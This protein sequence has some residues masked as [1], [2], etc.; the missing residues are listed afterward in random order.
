ML[1]KSSIMMLCFDTN[2]LHYLGSSSFQHIEGKSPS[3][4]H[5]SQPGRI[6]G[7]K[8]IESFDASQAPS[9]D[10]GPLV[11]KRCVLVKDWGKNQWRGTIVIVYFMICYTSYWWVFV[12]LKVALVT[13]CF[14]LCCKCFAAHIWFYVYTGYTNLTTHDPHIEVRKRIEESF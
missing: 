9:R 14:C 1:S 11:G 12:V 8:W 13:V 6:D 5:P 10:V 3:F 2:F 4:Q 7:L